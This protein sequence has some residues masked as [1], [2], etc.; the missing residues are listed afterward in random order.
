MSK[1]S[2]FFPWRKEF[3]VNIREIDNQHKELVKII[4]SLQEAINLGEG[5]ERLAQVLENLL[6]YTDFH[7]A[8]EEKLLKKHGYPHYE[9]HKRKHI[10]MR[11]KVISLIQDYNRGRIAMTFSVLKFL[12]DWL[13]KHIMGTDKLYG[14]YLNK[15]G[16]S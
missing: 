8:A 10:A 1:I 5:K 4:N 2:L 14:E 12:Q 13:S 15:K 7:F 16:V 6:A 11:E 3:E 9:E